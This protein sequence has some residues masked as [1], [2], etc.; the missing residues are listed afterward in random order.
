[1]NYCMIEV[2]WDHTASVDMPTH[3]G[4]FDSLEEARSW[5][6]LNVPNGRWEIHELTH[7]YWRGAV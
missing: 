5:G 6:V 7:P 1:M 2:E 4:P 3:I